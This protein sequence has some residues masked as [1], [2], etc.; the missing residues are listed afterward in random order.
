M[1]IGTLRPVNCVLN[2]AKML[3][4]I[5]EAGQNRG[6]FVE[7]IIKYAGGQP[8]DPWCAAFVYYV[9]HKM[10]GVAWPLPKTL[11]CDELLAYAIK[12][13]FLVDVPYPGCLFL[14]MK[15]STDATHV[16][17]VDTL[18]PNNRFTT[19]EGNSNDRG[20]RDGDGTVSNVRDINGPTTYRFIAWNL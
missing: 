20:I 13:E 15:S 10:L 18:L 7:A 3:L 19:V 2:A 8:G 6:R 11:S 12:H 1:A 4:P 16:G 5:R 9:G 17:F 14:V